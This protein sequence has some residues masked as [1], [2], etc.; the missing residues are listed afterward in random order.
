[1]LL[2]EPGPIRTLI[3]ED[4]IHELDSARSHLYGLTE[5]QLRHIFKAF[6]R[7]WDYEDKLASTLDHYKRPESKIN[8]IKAKSDETKSGKSFR[9]WFKD[10]RW[11]PD[12]A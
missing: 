7:G 9:G 10:V 12:T 11:V 6:H 4:M 3:K 2:S 1:M 8:W 5:P